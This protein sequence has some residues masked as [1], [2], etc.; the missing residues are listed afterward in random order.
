MLPHIHPTSPTKSSARANRITATPTT[1]ASLTHDP[2]PTPIVAT[3]VANASDGCL[4]KL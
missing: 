3:S 2:K 4:E 1:F